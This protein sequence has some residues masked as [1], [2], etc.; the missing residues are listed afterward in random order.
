MEEVYELY[1][2]TRGDLTESDQVLL[3]LYGPVDDKVCQYI[4]L[5][6]A[7]K[8]FFQPEDVELFEETWTERHANL[9]P[10]LSFISEAN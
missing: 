6:D 4:P 1:R 7:M 2:F 9:L 5:L 10:F 8:R 3:E